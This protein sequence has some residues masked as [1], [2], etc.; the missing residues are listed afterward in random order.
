MLY[1]LR[2]MFYFFLLFPI[3]GGK[4]LFFSLFDFSF[5]IFCVI[6]LLFFLWKRRVKKEEKNKESVSIKCCFLF[7]SFKDFFLLVAS[8]WG[9]SFKIQIIIQFPF[10]FCFFVVHSIFRKQCLPALCSKHSIFFK[11][12]SVILSLSVLLCHNQE[13]EVIICF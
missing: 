11:F 3:R 13:I 4:M 9:V 7:F 1:F 5:L 8:R 10:P 6:F 2:E 12:V